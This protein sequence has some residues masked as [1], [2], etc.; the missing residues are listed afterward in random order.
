MKNANGTVWTFVNTGDK[1]L[2]RNSLTCSTTNTS[3]SYQG[4]GL[5]ISNDGTVLAIGGYGENNYTGA[6][7]IFS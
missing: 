1:W 7:W 4:S 2:Q 6:T 5:A 3:N